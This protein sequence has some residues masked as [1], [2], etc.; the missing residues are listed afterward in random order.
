MLHELYGVCIDVY[1]FSQLEKV[2]GVLNTP[3]QANFRDIIDFNTIFDENI[4]PLKNCYY[5]SDN[6]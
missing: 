4:K 5:L 3:T 2:T 6:N 1:N